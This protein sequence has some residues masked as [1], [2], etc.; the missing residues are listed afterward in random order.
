MRSLLF[1]IAALFIFAGALAISHPRTS[2]VPHQASR[3]KPGT[4][5]VVSPRQAV[6][7]G[8]FSIGFGALALGAGIWWRK[9]NQA[10]DA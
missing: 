2:L 1:A 7:Y 5:E 6:V 10:E 8:V 3:Y 4:T 9:W